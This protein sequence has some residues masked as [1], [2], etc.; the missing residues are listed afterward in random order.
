MLS[1]VA[2]VF[3]NMSQIEID[4]PFNYHLIFTSLVYGAAFNSPL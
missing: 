2:A 3:R 1:W 4:K